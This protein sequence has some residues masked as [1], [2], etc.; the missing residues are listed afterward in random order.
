MGINNGT[1]QEDQKEIQKLR[2]EPEQQ[3]AQTVQTAT[4]TAI[5][6][7]PPVGMQSTVTVQQQPSPFWR[8]D[9]KISGQIGE[10]GQKDKLTFSSLAC[11]IE[12]SRNTGYPE[13]EIVDAVVRA[14]SPSL[15]LCSYLEG[16]PNLTLPTLRCIMRSHFQ[17][18]SATELYKQLASE[19]QQSKK[20]PQ[21]F[22]LRL[23]YLKQKV[24]FASQESETGLKYDP[25]LVQRMLLHTVL[26]GLRNDSV[27][28]DMQPLLLGN[29]ASD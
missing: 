27:R 17:E 14:I 21:S 19:V 25:A 1:G 6:N 26:T 12:N 24:L 16:K 9:F 3:T 13:I 23:L 8:K 28:I 10:P 22:L 18:K 29:E 7:S 11:Q 2:T 5:A 4:A 15:Q 20:I